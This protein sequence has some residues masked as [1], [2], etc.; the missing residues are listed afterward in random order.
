L[1]REFYKDRLEW[2]RASGV[3]YCRNS[4]FVIR[5][6]KGKTR[7]EAFQNLQRI[8]NLY[9]EG[10]RRW[11]KNG[12]DKFHSDQKRIKRKQKELAKSLDKFKKYKKQEK[13]NNRVK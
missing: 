5:V 9:H 11:L 13:L 10:N 4:L 8:L 12:D 7:R 3:W 6:G 2:T 1:N